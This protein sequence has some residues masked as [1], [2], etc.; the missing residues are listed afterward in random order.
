MPC[1]CL[2]V[3]KISQGDKFWQQFLT[4]K[5]F[6]H[7]KNWHIHQN[8]S[9]TCQKMSKNPKLTKIVTQNYPSDIKI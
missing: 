9:P 4:G 1:Q 8:V 2:F 7:A 5:N 3:P 6:V